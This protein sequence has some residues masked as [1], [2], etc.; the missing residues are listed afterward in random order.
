MPHR[1]SDVD[2]LVRDLHLRFGREL[3]LAALGLPQREVARRA[4][5]SQSLVSRLTHGIVMPDLELMVRLADAAGH[6]FSFKLYPDDGVG[7]RDSGQLEL[8]QIVSQSVH[9]SWRIG[10]EVPVALAPDRRA[11]D[12][13]L[14]H[15]HETILLEIERG[16]F[17]FQAQLR[18]A[19]LKRAALSERIGGPVTLV[20]G[21]PDTD[22]ARRKLHP[23]EATIRTTLPIS[24]RRAWASLRAGEPVRGDALIWI[25][26]RHMQTYARHASQRAH[27]P[28]PAG[29]DAPGA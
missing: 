13:V 17:D 28:V 1:R 2:Q 21:V 24:S 18:A 3:R 15:R 14:E 12:M 22:A 9:N 8:A 11:A 4:G 5:V 16:L 7:L 26:R 19:Q 10:L 20:V 23:H 25:R 6:R 29:R 27:G